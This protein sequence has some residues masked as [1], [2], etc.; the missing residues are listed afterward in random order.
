MSRSAHNNHVNMAE[1]V[2]IV[3]SRQQ[4]TCRSIVS[5]LILLMLL[6]ASCDLCTPVVSRLQKVWKRNQ[7]QGA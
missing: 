6:D 1:H 5:I 3:L 7:E 4:T 2:V